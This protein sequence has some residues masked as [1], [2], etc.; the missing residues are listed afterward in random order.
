M[1]LSAGYKSDLIEAVI[2]VGFDRIDQIRSR[3]DQLQNFMTA[4][5]E[6]ESLVLTFKRI[7]NILKKQED[8]YDIDPGLFKS[9][10]EFRLW[11]A[12]EKFR[13]EVVGSMERG[14]YFEALN[15]LVQLRKPVDDL[16]DEVEILTK[17]NPRLRN[18][19]IGMLQHLARLF[20]SLA[21]FS[22]FSI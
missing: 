9:P 6:F 1:V 16:F 18:N 10:S 22:K 5:T 13:D 14:A 11:E 3:I 8:A 2:S 4:S 21:D 7:N 15:I 20:L 12:Y 17:E 19:R